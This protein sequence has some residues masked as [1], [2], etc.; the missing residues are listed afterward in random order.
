MLNVGAE[1]EPSGKD[2]IADEGNDRLQVRI[3][4][5]F[6]Q[7]FTLENDFISPKLYSLNKNSLGTNQNI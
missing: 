2:S 5:S 6:N 4:E 3:K 1:E 7:Y